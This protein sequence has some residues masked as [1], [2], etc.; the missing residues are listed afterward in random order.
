VEAV[1]QEALS[2]EE[3]ARWEKIA[4]SPV[5]A[6]AGSKDVGADLADRIE[7][8]WIQSRVSFASYL[9]LLTPG[10]FAT[11]IGERARRQLRWFKTSINRLHANHERREGLLRFV[12]IACAIVAFAKLSL[13]LPAFHVSP[14]AKSWILAALFIGAA[15]ASAYTAFY[16]SNNQ[17]SLFHRYTTQVRQIREWL[18][19]CDTVTTTSP[20]DAEEARR[21]IIWFEALMAG[22]LVDW[23]R[24]TRH[25]SMELTP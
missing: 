13:A 16:L 7:A 14:A 11:Y 9:A 22:E 10:A 17:R 3:K 21:Q 19:R 24:I 1:G 23:V 18:R 12:F 2:G 4:R 20:F 15:W 25:D 8:L 5:E 6:A